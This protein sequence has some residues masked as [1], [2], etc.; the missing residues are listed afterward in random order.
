MDVTLRIPTSLNDI[1][2]GQYQK[3]LAID[4][5]NDL[6]VFEC[7]LNV[8]KEKVRFIPDSDVE[9][10]LNR[11]NTIFDV[12]HHLVNIF[13]MGG[14]KYGFIPNLDELTYGENKDITSTIDNWEL[15]HYA[16]SVLY[17]P[18]TNQHKSKYLIEPYTAKEDAEAMKQMPV[19][20]VLGALVF[21]YNL[22]KDLLTSIPNYL[23]AE[24]AKQTLAHKPHSEQS[25]EALANSIHLLRVTL[26]NLMRLQN[27]RFTYA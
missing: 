24:I 13:T 15:I 16:M 11:I 26:Q 17:R 22:T 7:F 19:S 14:V 25:G 2:L 8:P 23:E 20:A 27:N 12:E 18:I 3:Y 10:I 1:T 5:P 4:K 9:A 21:F 6:D